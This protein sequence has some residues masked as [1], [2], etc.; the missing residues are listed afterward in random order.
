MTLESVLTRLVGVVAELGL[1]RMKLAPVA[2]RAVVAT[3]KTRA[4]IT[5]RPT[6]KTV[7]LPTHITLP[8]AFLMTFSF[9]W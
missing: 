2:P 7:A 4:S 6:I 8:A 5:A 3:P 9:H 1:P